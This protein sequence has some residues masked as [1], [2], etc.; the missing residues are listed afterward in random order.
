VT[1][2]DP[3]RR[4]IPLLEAAARREELL[5]S[6]DALSGIEQ[7]RA[8]ISDLVQRAARV[9]VEHLGDVD[10][11]WRRLTEH[12]AEGDEQCEQALRDLAREVARGEALAEF[13]VGLAQSTGDPDVQRHRWLDASEVLESYLDDSGRALEATLRAFATNLEDR[14]VLDDVD[15]LGEAASAWTRVAQVYDTLLGQAPDDQAKVALLVRLSHLLDAKA[16]DPSGALDRIL[17]ACGLAVHDDAVLELAE[18]LA[19]RAE[20]AEELFIVYDRRRSAAKDDA[21]HVAALLRSATLADDALSDRA[22]ALAFVRQAILASKSPELLGVIETAMRVFD[23][24]RPAHGPGAAQRA[25][26]GMYRELA[27]KVAEDAPG[28]SAVMLRR[29]ARVQLEDLEDRSV[30]LS[31]L[32]QATTY[33]PDDTAILDELEEISEQDG[34]LEEFQKHLETLVADALDQGTAAALLKRRGRV[35]EVELGRPDEAADVFTRLHSLR[36]HDPEVAA[37]LKHC[38]RQAARHQDLL[39]ILEKEAARADHTKKVELYK[40]VAQIWETDIGNRWEAIDAWKRVLVEAP[41]D[42]DAVDTVSRLKHSTR[43]LTADE[44][45]SEG[46]SEDAPT[47]A[48]P[49]GESSP[50]PRGLDEETPHPI[51]APTGRRIEFEDETG[52]ETSDDTL[53]ELDPAQRA[54]LEE[55]MKSSLSREEAS[56]PVDFDTDDVTAP[57]TSRGDPDSSVTAEIDISQIE[58][59]LEPDAPEPELDLDTGDIDLLEVDGIE[60]DHDDIEELDDHAILEEIEQDVVGARAASVPPP[61]PPPRAGSRRPPPP[62]RAGS[63]PPPPP[64]GSRS[65][66]PPPLPGRKDD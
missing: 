64:S 39:L 44:L 58:E 13:Y 32:V 52:L 65:S 17:R 8:V 63:V 26:V 57:D 66:I 55:S 2:P 60:E 19:P 11:A 23:D 24:L 35:L 22:R 20:R 10:G 31:L 18:E 6:I 49:A 27:E 37:R 15:R 40:E 7:E 29:A 12:A 54:A 42:E 50:P 59:S 34:H 4:R 61:P 43:R 41:D 48:A 53:G 46:L 56:P 16:N 1:D 14:S 36:R 45:G 5:A 62:P 3:Q 47:T 33:A 30:A 51:L 9:C 28:A 25:L 21:G 38:L